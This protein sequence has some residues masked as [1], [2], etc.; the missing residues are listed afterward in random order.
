MLQYVENV[1]IDC[2][3]SKMNECLFKFNNIK[4]IEYIQLVVQIM[5]INNI[6]INRRKYNN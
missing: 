3:N 5:I 2:S 4:I 6:Q 1:G